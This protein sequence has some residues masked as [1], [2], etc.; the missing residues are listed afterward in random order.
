MLARN[1]QRLPDWLGLVVTNR[2]EFDVKTPLRALNSFPLDTKSESSRADIR[3]EKRRHARRKIKDGEKLLDAKYSS[4]LKIFWHI[5][6]LTLLLR[7][8]Q[9][10]SECSQRARL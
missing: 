1:A 8:H 10:R 5:L 9:R 3:D 7:C 2:P 4:L 6:N